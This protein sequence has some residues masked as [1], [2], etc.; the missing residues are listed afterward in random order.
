M[1][2]QFTNKCIAIL[3]NEKQTLEVKNEIARL[4]LTIDA[5]NEITK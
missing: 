5:Y 3:K 1:T 2:V 4:Q